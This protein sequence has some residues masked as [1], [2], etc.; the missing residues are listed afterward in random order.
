MPFADKDSYISAKKVL[1]NKNT[2]ILANKYFVSKHLLKLGKKIF[3]HEIMDYFNLRDSKNVKEYKYEIGI[4]KGFS[5]RSDEYWLRFCNEISESFLD[6][7]IG[8]SKEFLELKPFQDN[9]KLQVKVDEYEKIVNSKFIISRPTLGTINTLLILR[10]NFLTVIDEDKSDEI[11]E[12]SSIIIHN[13]W[14]VK[15]SNLYD[16]KTLID[17]Y[18][19]IKKP[20]K[21]YKTDGVLEAAKFID[22]FI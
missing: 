10:K 3:F 9:S 18:E 6:F 4:I 13:G 12:N 22:S 11:R 20:F 17:N 1:L 7:N 15:F 19:E 21:N 8:F 2:S 14:G 5:K 16:L